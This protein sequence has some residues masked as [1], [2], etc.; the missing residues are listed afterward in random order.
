MSG[1][2][3]YVSRVTCH[4]SLTPEATATDPPSAQQY[5]AADLD[6]DPSTMS[7]RD[8]KIFLILSMWRFP[9]TYEPNCLSGDQCFP[10]LL[11]MEY[12]Y[13]RAI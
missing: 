6:L 9:V 8:P 4:M 3:C 2:T 5:S 11:P 12:I 10:L 7:C 1:V 13:N